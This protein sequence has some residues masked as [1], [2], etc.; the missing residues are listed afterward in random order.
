MFMENNNV[1]ET[2][3]Q[4][5]V[6]STKSFHI[7]YIQ[8]FLSAFL[9]FGLA[10]IP[11]LLT[12]KGIWIYYGDFNVQQIPFYMHVQNAV[13]TGN[14]LYDWSTDLGGSF[15]GCYSF[16]LTGSPFFWLTCLFPNAAVPY[17][18]P[19]I[20]A[21]KYAVMATT[22]FAFAKR[23]VK[24]EAGAYI[25]SLLFAFSGYSGAV[26]VY[27]HFHD[28]MA[29]FPLYLIT[30]EDCMEKKKRVPFVLMTTLML[31]INYFFFV[32]TV[33]F[34]AIYYVAKYVLVK[35]ATKEKV[36]ML[37]RAL[38]CGVTGVALAGIYII[39]S[40]YYTLHNS[41]L[42]QI[43]SG[44]DLIAYSEPTMI[45]GI[46]KNMVMLPDISGLNSMLNQ[47]YSRVSGVAAYIPFFSIALVIAFFLYKKKEDKNVAFLKRLMIICGVFAAVPMLNAAFSALN[48]EY[49]ARWF[50]MPVLFMAIMTA[51]VIEEREEAHDSM[52]TGAIAVFIITAV[53]SIMALL[54][55]VNED[56]EIV[57]LGSLSNYEQLISEIVFSFIMI[58][59]LFVYTFKWYKKN[60][61]F[62]VILVICACF[63]T[64]ETMFITGTLC[65]PNERKGPFTEQAIKGESPL[66]DDGTFYRIETDED[67]YNYPMFW[68]AHSITSF[69][70]TVPDSVFAVYESQD[71]G[72]SVVSNMW[73]TRIGFR[74]ITSA[75]YYVSTTKTA[76]ETI[77]RLEDIKDLKDYSVFFDENGYKVYENGNYIPMGFTFE[78]YVTEEEYEQAENT[79]QNKDKLLT[80]FIVLSEEDAEDYGKILSHGSL[81][82]NTSFG[83]NGLAK[84]CKKRR[85]NACSSFTADSRGFTA[86][87]D[88]EKENL[89]FFSVPYEEG[90]KA[91][92]DGEETQI[93][94]ADF[95]FMAVDVKEG[96]H[97]IEFKYSL[98]G[99]KYGKLM[100]LAGI[101]LLVAMLGYAVAENIVKKKKDNE[102][103]IDS[104]VDLC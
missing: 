14:F 63:A 65:V 89:V 44:Y 12:S 21:L 69:I 93:I 83:Y 24:T 68:D 3:E 60:I 31:V 11:S 27:N 40:I 94:K 86:S 100:S 67:I 88:L 75:R 102:N 16:Y 25:A 62:S 35:E 56:G 15:L 72:R 85:E 59:L 46:I 26:L 28:A 81:E 66:P 43:L 41:R 9:I 47:S 13:K 42:S 64:T 90:F 101:V 48:Q 78:E 6:I 50:Y 96:T 52:Q 5:K 98:S 18:M 76:I 30:F 55:S 8:V 36:K 32:G 54:P 34:L 99:L 97:K 84:E 33:V 39:P 95:G 71:Y 80:K 1:N 22:A 2:V 51:S 49:Y 37:F 57:L 17:L 92:V 58:I 104:S 53:I 77:G 87:I 73:K 20:S 70:S 61:A 45:W 7:N 10:T 91:Y 103:S 19:W 79:A 29:F 4:T 74:A 82:N 38:Y 23:Y